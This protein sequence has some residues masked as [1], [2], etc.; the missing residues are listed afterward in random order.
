MNA[1]RASSTGRCT[2]E[3]LR[4]VPKNIN[5]VIWP[6]LAAAALFLLTAGAGSYPFL[7]SDEARHAGIVHNMWASRH[8][9]VPR[10]GAFP[11]LDGAPLH[12]WISL[13][14]IEVFGASEWALRL[15]SALAAVALLLFVGKAFLP[16]GTW[17]L[18]LILTCLFLLQPAL[19]MAGR[20]V[21]P[22]MLGL[23]LITVS[24][25]SFWSA[26]QYL[27]RGEWSTPWTFSAWVATALSGL[28]VGPLAILLP[29]VTV[30]LWLA[31]RKRFDVIAA[32]CWWP[33]MVAAAA[34]F[35]PWFWLVEHSYPGIV[36]AMLQRQALTLVGEG[37]H[38]WL[39]LGA[40]SCWLLVAAGGLP[41]L[42]CCICRYRDPGLRAAF[43]TPTAGLMAVWLLVSVLF[44][45]L[46]ALSPAGHAIAMVVPLLYFS[47][48]AMAPSEDGTHR[49]GGLCT[50]GAIGL[51]AVV[52][53]AAGIYVFSKHPSAAA[54]LAHTVR[55]SYNPFTDKVI[56]LDR[57]D[58]DFNFHMKTPKLVY[59]ATDWATG[60]NLA[61]LNWKRELS[62]SARFVPDV[63]ESLLLTAVPPAQAAAPASL[64]P[65]HDS[66][67]DG[68]VERL[69]NSLFN[70]LCAQRSI[71][72]WVI[73]SKEAGARYPIL[74]DLLPVVVSGQA[75]VWYLGVGTRPLRCTQR[76]QQH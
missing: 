22:D 32:L 62:D 54:T 23:L 68:V 53:G 44:H 7:T 61:S 26:A 21:A 15:P 52:I 48:L 27:E 19:L 31:C 36:S 17:R 66:V 8:Y 76:A 49:V 14:F 58:Y 12:Y 63:A 30:G 24:L 5:W 67:A 71:N 39:E 46:I 4:L 2:A 1:N 57:F 50:W 60:E 28:A 29:L 37:R 74:S 70:R 69:E 10:V 65:G 25:G 18:P 72:L 55:Q 3:R 35:V 73:G 33:A 41:L 75:Y 47:A 42:V 40:G 45:P 20:F 34:L 59:V 64:G 56:M 13:G 51:L 9:L 38:E 16:S 43:R 11:V 6:C